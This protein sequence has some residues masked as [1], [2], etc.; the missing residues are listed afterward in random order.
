MLSFKLF[1]QWRYFN[2]DLEINVATLNAEFLK[3]EITANSI[4]IGIKHQ[5]FS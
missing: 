3:E 5:L 4:G 1:G 2:F